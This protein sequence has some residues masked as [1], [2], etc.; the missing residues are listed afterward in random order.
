MES[1]DVATVNGNA[2]RYRVMRDMTANRHVHDKQRRIVLRDLRN[3]SSDTERAT[4]KLVAG[5]PLVVP[6]GIRHRARVEGRVTLLVID[7]IC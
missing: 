5:Q 4:Q 1:F 2:V 3:R 7:T 6:S